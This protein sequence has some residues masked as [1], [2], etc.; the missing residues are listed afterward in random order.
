M[1]QNP[2]P[3]YQ[4]RLSVWA[5]GQ[6]T[7]AGKAS[8]YSDQYPYTLF[9]GQPI[10][11]RYLFTMPTGTNPWGAVLKVWGVPGYKDYES[12]VLVAHDIA[13]ISLEPDV[14]PIKPFV[15]CPREYR[16]N[17]CGIHVAGLPAIPGGAK[18]PTLVLSWFIDRYS[19]PDRA[20]IYAAYKALGVVD[21][22]ISW[23]DSR[24]NGSSPEQ[25]GRFCQELI[26]EGFQPCV[27]LLSKYYDPPDVEGCKRNIE[28]VMPSIASVV[29]RICVGWELSLWLQP[30]QVQQLTDWLSPLVNPWGGRLY[31]HFQAGYS[32]FDVDG[33]NAS[34]AGYWNRNIG[35]LTGVLHQRPTEDPEWDTYKKYQDRLV[36][37]LE[38]FAGHFNCSPDSGFG[39]PFDIIALEITAQ[40][41]YNGWM[42]TEQGN[43]WGLAAIQ[44]PTSH[45][46][47][48]PVNVKGSGNGQ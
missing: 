42:T 40:D 37:V 13:D 24:A 10:D 30:V 48:G 14:P 17:M 23:P 44:T 33:P 2:C 3:P 27:M 31:V 26:V 5:G 11:N 19:Q 34:F 25:F 4:A 29:G 7:T 6:L 47:L 15:P 36:D 28:P 35:K 1:S 39:H 32:S 8:L 12:R 46:P 9:Y 38:R 43:T 22:L 20:G 45:G 18:D 41:Q 16:G 21:V